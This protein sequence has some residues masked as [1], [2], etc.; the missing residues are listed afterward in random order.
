MKTRSKRFEEALTKFTE[1]K[2]AKKKELYEGK[3]TKEEYDRLIK[4]KATELDL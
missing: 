1:Y 3:I 4:A 2:L